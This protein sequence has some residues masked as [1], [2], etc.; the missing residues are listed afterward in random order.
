[1]SKSSQNSY[2]KGVVAYKKA[3]KLGKCFKRVFF[4]V[5]KDVKHIYLLFNELSI[6]LNS[7]LKVIIK[8]SRSM[9]KLIIFF[10][11][12]ILGTYVEKLKMYVKTCL[13][14]YL[15]YI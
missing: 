10:I 3:L 9:K 4:I 5:I 11:L 15:S 8:T 2:I 1:M 14:I 7:P 6:K 12:I 13:L